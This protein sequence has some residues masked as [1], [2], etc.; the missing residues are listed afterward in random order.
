MI[1]P[2]IINII[3][4]TTDI[5]NFNILDPTADPKTLEAS[6][7]PMIISIV[8]ISSISIIFNF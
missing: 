5:L 2:K 4:N 6:F 7:A 1:E 8:A 3:K